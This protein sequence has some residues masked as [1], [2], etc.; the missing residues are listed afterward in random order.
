MAGRKIS[1]SYKIGSAKLPKRIKKASNGSQR[2]GPNDDIRTS[3]RPGAAQCRRL[4]WNLT[5]LT[6]NP[7]FKYRCS[8]HIPLFSYLLTWNISRYSRAHH[9]CANTTQGSLGSNPA[10][11]YALTIPLW[12][13]WAFVEIPHGIKRPQQDSAFLIETKL[14]KHMHTVTRWLRVEENLCNRSRHLNL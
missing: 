1:I 6:V 10:A 8:L 11:N 4:S 9:S 13:K 2:G 7:V 3:P 14:G 5:L 12:P